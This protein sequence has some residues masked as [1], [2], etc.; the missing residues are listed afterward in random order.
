MK[1]LLIVDDEIYARDRLAGFVRKQGFNVITASTGDE[2]IRAYKENKPDFVFLDVMLP[3]LDGDDVFKY[4][5][6]FDPAAVVYFITGRDDLFVSNKTIAQEAK[7]LLAKPLDLQE[8][9]RILDREREI[10]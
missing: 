7:G 4:I 5:K 3:D 9:A 2:G 10:R 1:T 6:E 8:I